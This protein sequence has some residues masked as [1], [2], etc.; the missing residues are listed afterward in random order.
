MAGAPQGPIYSLHVFEREDLEPVEDPQDLLEAAL[1]VVTDAENWAEQ[2]E[3]VICY[4]RLA[5][6]GV[7]A[8]ELL[9]GALGPV[10]AHV[11]QGISSERS[12]IARNS[13]MCMGELFDVFGEKE[14]LSACWVLHLPAIVE[15]LLHRSAGGPKFVC[16]AAK[17]ALASVAAVTDPARLCG[18]LRSELRERQHDV[19]GNAVCHVEGCLSRL[20]VGSAGRA[21]D[22]ARP[23]EASLGAQEEAAQPWERRLEAAG[24]MLVVLVGELAPLC[25]SRSET[26]RHYAKRSLRRIRRATGEARFERLLQ[27]SLGTKAAVHSVLKETELKRR[28]SRARAHGGIRRPGEGQP[29]AMARIPLRDRIRMSRSPPAFLP[30][31]PQ[32]SAAPAARENAMEDSIVK[33]LA[34]LRLEGDGRCPRT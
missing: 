18:V 30:L 20:G 8:Q 2:H 13:L 9:S 19:V 4:R 1:Q 22:P 15:T 27:A 28:P 33:G 14:A 29:G 6:S 23:A 7:T 31:A 10:L 5:A 3:A 26:G 34:G 32:Q 25:H 12:A 16:N 24:T 17:D 21:V 11:L